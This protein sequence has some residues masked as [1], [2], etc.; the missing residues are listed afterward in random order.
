MLYSCAYDVPM[1]IYIYICVCVEQ[2]AAQ[3]ACTQECVYLKT[4]HAAPTPRYRA[5]QRREA[6]GTPEIIC[7]RQFLRELERKLTL[8][9]LM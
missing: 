1:N 4:T 7:T 9:P 6:G 2:S 5:A 8:D 3:T